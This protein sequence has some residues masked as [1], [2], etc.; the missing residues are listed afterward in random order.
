MKM[1]KFLYFLAAQANPKCPPAFAFYARMLKEFSKDCDVWGKKAIESNDNFAV[2]Y[3]YRWGLSVEADRKKS[4]EL[5]LKSAMEGFD[6][7]QYNV[8]KK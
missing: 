8:G 6:I 5:Y 2:A 4:F 7:G 1:T 3:C